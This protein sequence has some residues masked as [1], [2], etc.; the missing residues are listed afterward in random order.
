MNTLKNRGCDDYGDPFKPT[1]AWN[2]EP[3]KGLH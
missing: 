1:H 3:H 2:I